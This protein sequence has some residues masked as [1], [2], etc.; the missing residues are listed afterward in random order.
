MIDKI[1]DCL[2]YDFVQI[3]SSRVADVS[4]WF[5]GQFVG[6]KGTNVMSSIKAKSKAF[7]KALETLLKDLEEAQSVKR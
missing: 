1:R 6:L 2:Y 4:V 5:R 3:Y 7:S